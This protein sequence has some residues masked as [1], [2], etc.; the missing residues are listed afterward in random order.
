MTAPRVSVVVTCYNMGEYLDEAVGS[1]LAQSYRDFEILVVDDGSTDERTRRMLDGYDKPL[2]RVLRSSNRGLSA[3]R[4]LGIAHTTGSYI[5]A[6][7]ADDLL[8]PTMLEKSVAAL[9][10]DPSIAFVSHW[11][12]TFGD[13]TWEWTPTRCDFPALLHE[14]TVNGA[15]LVRRSALEAVGGF[16]ETFQDGC[17]DWDLWITM[18]ERGLRGRILPEILFRY[19]RR[20]GSMSR[21]MMEGDRHPRMYHRIAEKHAAAFRQYRDALLIK[22]EEEMHDL[23]RHIDYLELEWYRWVEPG[24]AKQRDDV[25]RLERA[26]VREAERIRVKAALDAAHF[27]AAALRQSMSWRVTAPLRAAYDILLRFSRPRTP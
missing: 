21:V 11:F 1:V 26:A 6:L 24:L 25:A 18:V 22:R 7:D 23:G 4:N 14:N 16:D 17:E 8:E 2:T 5:C 9:D 15:S 12:R 27:Q 10:D 19:R 20:A 13:E 3:A